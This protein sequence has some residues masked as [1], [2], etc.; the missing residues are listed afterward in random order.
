MPLKL[1][2][3]VISL[4]AALLFISFNLD[5]RC[6]VSV[7]FHTFRNVPAFLSLL[8]AYALGAASVLPFV[9]GFMRK[10]SKRDSRAATGKGPDS[11][12]TKSG[13]SRPA[14]VDRELN[15][16]QG[17]SS[18]DTRPGRKD[19]ALKR[20]RAAKKAPYDAD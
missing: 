20:K 11:G 2:F 1:V 13:G 4:V 9:F 8:A 14:Q 18:A 12:K 7:V 17:D 10:R 5:N 19:R 3:F 15:P 6:D 16:E